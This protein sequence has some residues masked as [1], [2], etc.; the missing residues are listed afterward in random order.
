MHLYWILTK[1]RSSCPV[2]PSASARASIPF[3]SS[4]FCSCFSYFIIIIGAAFAELSMKIRCTLCCTQIY[5]TCY[6]I[7]SIYNSLV[8][9][10]AAAA[11]ARMRFHEWDHRI[12]C[13][14]CWRFHG[15][16]CCCWSARKRY[17]FVLLL[18][19]L[20]RY[21]NF[22]EKKKCFFFFRN[23]LLRLRYMHEAWASW[24]I[25]S[26]AKNTKCETA[27]ME[28]KS[29][30]IDYI[31]WDVTFHSLWDAAAHTRTSHVQ[32]ETSKRAHWPATE[33]SEWE[34]E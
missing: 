26:V 9:I 19:L 31:V 1:L 20:L 29:R 11:V 32:Y 24:W 34:S 16:C 30:W 5:E 33:V 18:L 21:L 14:W 28:N 17:Y 3:F 4:S 27:A 6:A 13:D 25:L 2:C 12:E 23:L 7:H 15:R 8:V 22:I 10:A